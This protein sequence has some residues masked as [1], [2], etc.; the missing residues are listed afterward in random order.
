MNDVIQRP[1]P[2]ELI[3]LL[4]LLVRRHKIWR[5]VKALKIVT[6]QYS[7]G[8]SKRRKSESLDEA[9]NDADTI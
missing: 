6:D 3:S 4:E 5:R 9:G 1:E 8:R 2:K 7:V